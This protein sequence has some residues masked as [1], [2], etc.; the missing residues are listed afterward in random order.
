[1]GRPLP[2]HPLVSMTTEHARGLWRGQWVINHLAALSPELCSPGPRHG[3]W[4]AWEE[5]G[6]LREPLS[7]T[8]PG[9]PEDRYCPP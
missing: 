6:G 5:H 8:F 9:V 2:H 4:E 1:M 3:T 7:Y